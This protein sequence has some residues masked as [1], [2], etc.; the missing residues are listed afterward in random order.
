M[1]HWL[2]TKKVEELAPT[3]DRVIVASSDDTVPQVM[4][5]FVQH[6][7]SCVPVLDRTTNQFVGLLD[8][9]DLVA[10]VINVFEAGASSAAHHSPASH[11][12]FDSPSP[13][14]SSSQS[15]QSH[16]SEQQQ[17]QQ[18][19]FAYSPGGS[20]YLRFL[21]TEQ[22][23]NQQTVGSLAD[24]TG[25]AP[26]IPVEF[27]SSVLEAVKI[28]VHN[29]VHRVP[30]VSRIPQNRLLSLL[31]QSAVIAAIAKDPVNILGPAL[32]KRTV[33]DL[34]LGVSPVISVS[35][36][37]KTL[38]AFKILYEKRISGL[39]I[40]RDG[41]LIGNI[42]AKDLRAVY[43]FGGNMFQLMNL[44]VLE[45][46]NEIRRDESVQAVNPGIA[47]TLETP[48][49]LVIRRLAVKGIHRIYVCDRHKSPIRIITLSHVLAAII[50]ANQH[51]SPPPVVC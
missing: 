14:S 47:V 6:N 11:F 23:F 37:T 2:S 38:D 19:N 24:I 29:P 44:S 35:P 41:L 48:F 8:I 26:F 45:F 1:S 10:F 20:E 15:S 25:R 4:K 5:I 43:K 40:V 21:E 49:E 17:Q 9:L 28:F 3:M 18:Q 27:G 16:G 50:G 32:A 12:V 13:S 31:T 34:N 22:R 39:P 46:V 33:G 42:S 30:I 36:D 7:I 51:T